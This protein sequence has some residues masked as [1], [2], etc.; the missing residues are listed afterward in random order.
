MFVLFIIAFWVAFHAV[1]FIFLIGLDEK[2]A[3]SEW[4]TTLTFTFGGVIVWWL[5]KSVYQSYRYRRKK[6]NKTQIHKEVA[7]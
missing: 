3:R 4:A 1:A 2:W 7:L 6:Q 5:A